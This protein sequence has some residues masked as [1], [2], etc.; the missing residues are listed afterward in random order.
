MTKQ[1]KKKPGDGSRKSLAK[2]TSRSQSP[3]LAAT[4]THQPNQKLPPSARVGTR[5]QDLP[6]QE[7]EFEVWQTVWDPATEFESV[8]P[9]A[10]AV[11]AVLHHALAVD[12][13]QA[14]HP[15]S[16]PLGAKVV[17]GTQVRESHA[18]RIALARR[19]EEIDSTLGARAESLVAGA[20]DVLTHS[21]WALA[22]RAG[23]AE[24]S[25]RS[26][27]RVRLHH[28][29]NGYPRIDG[30]LA[31]YLGPAARLCASPAVS[32]E[33]YLRCQD[34][35]ARTRDDIGDFVFG[36]TSHYEHRTPWNRWELYEDWILHLYLLDRQH[37]NRSAGRLRALASVAASRLRELANGSVAD[38][39]DGLLFVRLCEP[40]RR[41]LYWYIAD[42][43]SESRE[44][45]LA[46][47]LLSDLD[48]ALRSRRPAKQA[49][50]VDDAHH[51]AYEEIKRHVTEAWNATRRTGELEARFDRLVEVFNLLRELSARSQDT[52]RGD[53]RQRAS[54]ELL[55]IKREIGSIESV[56]P[57]HVA[58]VLLKHHYRM[59]LSIDALKKSLAKAKDPFRLEG[60]R[61]VIG[62]DP[63]LA[64]WQRTLSFEPD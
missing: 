34:R 53:V 12:V 22:M 26:S 47:K 59:P 17:D 41:C 14:T 40:L 32:P 31:Q 63:A 51:E 2:K 39:V 36:G 6:L 15:K 55:E 49:Y 58:T 19:V 21:P 10:A 57:S 54:R 38:R 52:S 45:K 11:R 61:G 3:Q 25:L 23:F 9:S 16:W 30:V 35:A 27:Q 24:P 50:L 4:T 64:A 29:I 33:W 37:A 13:E 43:A 8:A 62:L 28:W 1:R 48:H 60:R 20:I 46:A 42:P 5:R 18:A 7:S 56:R 44:K